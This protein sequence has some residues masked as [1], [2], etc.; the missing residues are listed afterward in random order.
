MTAP[1]PTRP[2]IPPIT[3]LRMDATQ[4]IRRLRPTELFALD[5]VTAGVVTLICLLAAAETP[6]DGLPAEPGWASL[7]TALLIGLPIAVRRRWPYLVAITV[8]V[9]SSIAL[10]LEVIPAF[11]A[12]GP[13]CALVLAFYTFGAAA[14]DRRAFVIEA[15]CS[16]LL[17][18][19][20]VGPM[21]LAGHEDPG[22]DAPSMF[23]SVLFGGLVVAPPAILGFAIGERRAQ[24]AQRSEQV[25]REAAI[26]ERLRLARELHDI[27]AHTMTLIV[28]KASIG[29]HVAER[30]PAEA[31]DAL[32]VI[33]KT[34]RAAMLEV[35]KMLDTLRDDTPYAPM[36]GLD[37]LPALVAMASSSGARV[38]LTVDRPEGPANAWMPE[39]V[40]LAVYRIVQ[41]SVTNVVKHAAPAQCQVT[42]VV[43]VT[44]VQI[45]V[46]DD[47]TRPPGATRTGHGLIGMR[48]RVALHGGTFRAGPRDGGGFSVTALLPVDGPPSGGDV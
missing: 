25:R 40:Q 21:L 13:A 28:V 32:Q 44:T 20:L 10:G 3:V 19:S 5:T 1:R 8:T 41:E 27:I 39:S 4:L 14:R 18:L 42:V 6:K 34:G 24:N 31:R 16:F 23:M 17:S 22:P 48:E 7:L 15:A 33:E 47:G 26:Q 2:S 45:E 12:P 9:A 38:T 35:H 46:I 11:A 29:N 43:G 36:P 37:D 30:D